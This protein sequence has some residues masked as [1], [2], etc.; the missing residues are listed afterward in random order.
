MPNMPCWLTS[1]SADTSVAVTRFLADFTGSE[2]GAA[3]HLVLKQLRARSE[4]DRVLACELAWEVHREGYW[5]QLKH[6]DGSPYDSE[7]SYFRDV[8]GLASWRTAYK[9]LAIGRMLAAITEAERPIF[10]AAI[11][12][13]GL[14][15]ASIIAPAIERTGQWAFWVEQSE[16][17]PCVMLQ[18]RVSEALEAVP[19]GREPLAPGEYF[20]RAVFSALPDIEAME[21][22]DRFFDVGRRVVGT[23][24]AV[25]IFLAGCRECLSDWEIRAYQCGGSLKAAGRHHVERD[26]NDR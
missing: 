7:E 18:R 15:K 5:S 19:R 8:L 11:A 21:L 1:E 17:L 10:R 23:D 3:L 22:V 9:R 12:T 13:I 6:D 20:R 4:P 26:L 25:A 14:A 2:R 24:H 16:R